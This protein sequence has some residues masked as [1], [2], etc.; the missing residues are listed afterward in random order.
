LIGADCEEVPAAVQPISPDHPTQHFE[1]DE[2]QPFSPISTCFCPKAIL[3]YN[4]ADNKES[5]LDWNLLNGK[6][7]SWKSQRYVNQSPERKNT[8]QNELP[9][10]DK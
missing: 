8:R 1:H 5:I 4:R 6:K 10:D 7:H 2:D 3:R 9:L